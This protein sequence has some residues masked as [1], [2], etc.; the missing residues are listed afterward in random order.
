MNSESWFKQHAL[1]IEYMSYSDS[2]NNF[3]NH[4][5]WSLTLVSMFT[6]LDNAIKMGGKI[7][8]RAGLIKSPFLWI[9]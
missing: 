6:L 8:L 2:R 3:E 1:E 9:Y 7:T 5:N 4:F